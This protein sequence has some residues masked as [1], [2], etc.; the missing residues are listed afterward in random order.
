MRQHQEQQQR[1]QHQ[2]LAPTLPQSLLQQ[3]QQQ[4]ASRPPRLGI[5]Q[6]LRGMLLAG[7]LF[8]VRSTLARATTSAL[9]SRVLCLELE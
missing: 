1:Q 4:Q 3:Q 6:R 9:V 8:R 2:H 7:A 5:G